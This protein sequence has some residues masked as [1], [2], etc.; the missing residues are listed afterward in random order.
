MWHTARAD[1]ERERA[2][3]VVEQRLPGTQ[4][5]RAEQAR[6]RRRVLAE[7]RRGGRVGHASRAPTRA[8]R[9]G[10]RRK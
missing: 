6:L 8:R 9:V 1:H 10:K 7:Q 3:T 4:R 2:D 5:L